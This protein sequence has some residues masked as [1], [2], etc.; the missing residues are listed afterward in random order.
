MPAPPASS[1]TVPAGQRAQVESAWSTYHAK[2]RLIPET[3]AGTPV[4]N[5]GPGRSLPGPDAGHPLQPAGGDPEG[6]HSDHPG[7]CPDDTDSQADNGGLTS[8]KV[9]SG[10][11][12]DDIKIVKRRD[13]AGRN[14][15][16]E[17]PRRKRVIA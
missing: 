17:Q 1:V 6:R 13:S 7:S 4:R 10:R 12:G 9:R 15:L 5:Q 11:D 2:S 14:T 16:V 8:L 3:S